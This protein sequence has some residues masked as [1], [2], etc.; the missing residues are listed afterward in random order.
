V[1]DS[2]DR[3]LHAW[4]GIDAAS[5][6][7]YRERVGTLYEFCSQAFGI[8]VDTKNGNFSRYSRLPDTYR[9]RYDKDGEV[10]VLD[11]NGQQIWD[12][13]RLLLTDLPGKSWEEWSAG[14]TYDDGSETIGVKELLEF[15]RDSDESTLIGNRWLCKGKM[16]VLQGP[17]GV[18]KSSLIMQWAIRLILR[19]AFFGIQP[20]QAMKVLIIQAE[21]D[22][23]DMAEAFQDMIDAMKL[24]ADDVEKLEKGLRIVNEDSRTGSAF[25]KFLEAKIN[26]HKPDIV[27]VDPLLA[28]IGGDMLKQE[29]M[30]RFLRNEIN[31]VLRRTNAL[32]IWVHHVSKPSNNANGK[33]P[34]AEQ[35]KYAGL[36]SSELQNT[37]REIIN[38]S[39]Q[40]AGIF[41]LSFTKRGG[42]LGITG[43]DGKPLRKFNIEHN[44]KGIVWGKC[45]GPQATANKKATR[46]LKQVEQVGKYIESKKTVDKDTLTT[47]AK[48][49]DIGRDNAIAMAKALAQEKDR[50]VRVYM[51][52][53]PEYN[54]K[55]VKPKVFSIVP[56]PDGKE[57]FIAH[58][59]MPILDRIELHEAAEQAEEDQK[60]ERELDLLATCVPDDYGKD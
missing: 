58:E 53:D 43:E 22:R 23:G 16:A 41:E 57:A 17:T 44:S 49:Q 29:V 10:D 31:P 60:R 25:V 21:N 5:E 33:E 12:A 40:S 20:A 59:G 3:S 52:S 1:V 56:P 9:I 37:C 47:W 50:K 42:R 51:Y 6:A 45:E 4:V 39:E 19:L 15:D 26:E 2:A 35:N 48:G 32:L 8:Q 11:E 24:S 30:S 54:E 34:S 18:G 55:G 36:G 38:L 28:Y 14:L 7:E 13:Q 46:H 27:F